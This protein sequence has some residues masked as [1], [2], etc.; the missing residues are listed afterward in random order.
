MAE[1]YLRFQP[2]ITSY[3]RYHLVGSA[4]A[5]RADDLAED[6]SADVF[7]RLCEKFGSYRPQDGTPFSAWLY[8]IA[9]NHL[10]DFLRKRRL[11][12]VSL[13]VLAEG[14]YTEPSDTQA[15]RAFEVADQAGELAAAYAQLPDDHRTVLFHRFICDRSLLQTARLTGKSQDSV[16]QLQVRAL[17]RLK[18][19]LGV[20]PAAQPD[21]GAARRH[22]DSGEAAGSQARTANRQYATV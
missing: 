17:R 1:L 19:H 21:S 2:K 7:V 16:K 11:P 14:G 15:E 10:I 6:L 22:P 20:S 9:H 13:A 4:H 8:R 5:H 12:G 18:A 3:F